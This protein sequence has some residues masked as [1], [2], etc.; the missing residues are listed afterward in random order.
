VPVA[1]LFLAVPLVCLALALASLGVGVAVIAR[2]P[3]QWPARLGIALVTVSIGL[4]PM[5]FLVIV[6]LH[7]PAGE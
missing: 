3:L 4:T 2:A 6:A 1:V 7:W 5:I